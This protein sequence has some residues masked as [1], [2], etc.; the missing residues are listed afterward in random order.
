[1][2]Q[3]GRKAASMTP[4]PARH[5]A[6]PG[7]FGSVAGFRIGRGRDNGAPQ[8]RPQHPPHGQQTPQGQPYGY[9]PAPPQPG[10]PQPPYTGGG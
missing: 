1:M 10:P 5:C 4:G 2:S 7:T 3:L 8:T 9:P 6:G